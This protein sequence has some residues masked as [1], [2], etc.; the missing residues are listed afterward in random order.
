VVEKCNQTTQGTPVRRE[1]HLPEHHKSLR[2]LILTPT[3]SLI[4]IFQD[5]IIKVF[6]PRS[7]RKRL[8]IR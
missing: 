4:S 5:N 2:K 3:N 6:Y 8:K 1:M 7:N